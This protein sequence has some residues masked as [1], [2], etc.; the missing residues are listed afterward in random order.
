MPSQTTMMA[1]TTDYHLSLLAYH[2][3]VAV[4]EDGK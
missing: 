3:H 2:H 4:Y 1:T